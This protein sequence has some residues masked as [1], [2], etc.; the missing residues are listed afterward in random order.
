MFSVENFINLRD[1]NSI[2]KKSQRIEL[3]SFVHNSACKQVGCFCEARSFHKKRFP[4]DTLGKIWRGGALGVYF[5][6][7]ERPAWHSSRT[8]NNFVCLFLPRSQSKSRPPAFIPARSPPLVGATR[9]QIEG[10]LHAH[11]GALTPR[12]YVACHGVSEP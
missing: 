4:R 6:M 10:R 5:L 3:Q 9:G 1:N 12:L 11:A 8:S 7:I 2:A